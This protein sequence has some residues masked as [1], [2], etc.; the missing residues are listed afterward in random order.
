[1][2]ALPPESTD[3]WKYTYENAVAVHSITF[4]TLTGTA[5]AA[6][7]TIL[8]TLVGNLGA[9][10]SLSTITNLEFAGVG[11]TIFDP[12]AG[13]SMVDT[14]FGSGTAI[15]EFNATAATFVGRATGGRRSR[16]S[17]FGWKSD[18][19]EFR[20]T[21]AESS[22]VATVLVMLN[23]PAT[24]LIAING[25]PVTWHQYVDIKANDHWVDLSR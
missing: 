10:C 9:G 8:N 15:K 22:D 7:D 6:V 13:S 11:D 23:N 5:L 14:T 3:R 1:M 21:S 19:S 20:L 17:L 2:A 4:R 18:V 16:I 25:N 12:V 24:P